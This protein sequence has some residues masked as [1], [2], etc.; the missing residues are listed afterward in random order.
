MC[1]LPYPTAPTALSFSLCVFPAWPPDPVEECS[2]PSLVWGSGGAEDG[3]KAQTQATQERKGR[4]ESGGTIRWLRVLEFQQIMG[5]T[6]V[7]SRG[8]ELGGGGGQRRPP[9]LLECPLCADNCHTCS[10]LF[11][12]LPCEVARRGA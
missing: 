2:Q 6:G 3:L 1:R 11:P 4:L 9:V 8:E 10:P 5:P 7:K 12:Q